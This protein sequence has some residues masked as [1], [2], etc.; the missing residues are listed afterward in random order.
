MKEIIHIE[1][2]H[3]EL[4]KKVVTGKFRRKIIFHLV[5]C[6]FIGQTNMTWNMMKG[7][8]ETS[9]EFANRI[10]KKKLFN[11]VWQEP[12]SKRESESSGGSGMFWTY[13][14]IKQ[15]LQSRARAFC[16][17]VNAQ[18]EPAVRRKRTSKR[19]I[20]EKSSA[21]AAAIQSKENRKYFIIFWM[22]YGEHHRCNITSYNFHRHK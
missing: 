19:K 20:G 14:C 3:N 9:A 10:Y 1:I 12:E 18:P 5:Y 16:E 21:F 2:K 15:L 8:N 4:Q 17:C 7:K 11:Y 13:K 6:T 22:V